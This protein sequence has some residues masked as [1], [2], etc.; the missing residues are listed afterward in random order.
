MCTISP[1][2]FCLFF[3]TLNAFFLRFLSIL[4][5]LDC[6]SRANAVDVG[7]TRFPRFELTQN[8]VELWL[9]TTSPDNFFFFFVFNGFLNFNEFF[10]FIFVITWDPMGVKISKH[11]F[12]HSYGSLS[13]KIFL[14][15]PCDKSY[16]LGF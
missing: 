5:Q 4:A 11:Y 6:V 12:S 13:R 8:F 1:D 7:K 14:N 15:I 10:F 3:E 9:L 2:H 16:L